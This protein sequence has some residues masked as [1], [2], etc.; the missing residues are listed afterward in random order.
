MFNHYDPIKISMPSFVI[1]LP[2]YKM[3]PGLKDCVNHG[4]LKNI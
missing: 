4:H 3:C 1:L 2:A